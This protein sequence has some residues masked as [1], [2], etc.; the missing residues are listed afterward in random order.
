MTDGDEAPVHSLWWRGVRVNRGP[1]ET[2]PLD[3]GDRLNRVDL[4]DIAARLCLAM[5]AGA[6][7]SFA[8]FSLPKEKLVRPAAQAV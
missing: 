6:R 1:N 7:F 2:A 5:N 4:P 3:S 8:D